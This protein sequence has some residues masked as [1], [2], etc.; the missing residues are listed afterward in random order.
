MRNSYDREIQRLT[1]MTKKTGRVEIT[2]LDSGSFITTGG[3]SFDE[4]VLILEEN[5]FEFK[6]CQD[7]IFVEDTFEELLEEFEDYNFHS[8]EILY[9]YD[10]TFLVLSEAAAKRKVVV[11]RGKRSVI[12]KC[13]PGQHKVSR[14]RCAKTS[15]AA[16]MKMKRR[17]KRSARKSK[18]K[19]SQANRR[20]KIS[21]RRRPHRPSKHKK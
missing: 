18:R 12:Y 4:I 3:I 2:E 9:E 10:S 8:S 1:E 15:S 20:R 17:A 16:L 6:I 13:M 14:T 5:Y 21:L 11:R 7:G 19:R